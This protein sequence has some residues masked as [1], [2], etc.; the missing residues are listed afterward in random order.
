MSINEQQSAF[1][2]PTAVSVGL[3]QIFAVTATS[4]NPA[5]VVLTALDRAEYTA[6]E[7]GA[8][9][10]FFGNGHTLNLTAVGGDGGGAGIVFTLQPNGRYYNSYIWL[11]RPVDLQFFRQRRGCDQPLAVR[12]QQPELGQRKRQ[13]RLCNDAG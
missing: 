12:H 2:D 7:A 11:P 5:Y 6:G 9:G 8:T 4:A 13:Q 1:V 10:N 3:S